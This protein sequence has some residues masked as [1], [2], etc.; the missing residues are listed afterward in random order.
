MNLKKTME[1][2]SVKAMNTDEL[3]RLSEE[4][5]E[6]LIDNVSQTGGHLASNLGAVE[7]TIALYKVFDF[8][9]DKLIFDVGH[10]S[11]V[12]KILSGRIDGFSRLRQYGGMSGFPKREESEFDV[13][14]SGHSSNSISVALGLKRAMDLK[15]EKGK[16]IAFIGDGALTGGMAYEALND[17]G[18]SNAGIIIILNDNEMSI[19]ENVG[20]IAKHLAKIR[21]SKKYYRIKS[22][23]T[24]V[25]EAVPIIGAPLKK[26]LSDVKKPIRDIAAKKHNNIFEQLGFYYAGPFDGHNIKEL[27]EAFSSVGTLN[28]PCVVHIV[29]KKGKGYEFAQNEPDLYHGVKKFDKNRKIER[30]KEENFSNV[31]GDCLCELA[32]EN[33]NIVAVT[34]AMPDGTGLNEFKNE[35]PERYYDV[36]IAEGHA[37]GLC[38]GLAIGNVVPV[39]AVYSAFL[40]RGYDQLLTDVC[41]MNLHCVFCVDRSGL[42]GEDGETHHG[43]FDIAYLMLIPNITVMSPSTYEEMKLMLKSAVYDYDSPVVIRYA[44]GKE[45]GVLK[46][47]ERPFEKGKA[48]VLKAGTDVSIICEG[49]MCGEALKTAELLEKDGINAEVVNLRYI[50]PLDEKTVISSLEKTKKGVILENGSKNG[51]IYSYISTLTDKKLV[52]INTGDKFVSQGSIKELRKELGMDFESIAY[53]IKKELF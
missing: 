47:Y 39:F 23:T 41:G 28:K 51:G 5:R 46:K 33:E 40:L 20:G 7:A 18:R 3:N 26:F 21:T 53:R 37:V 14:N 49:T 35:F 25:F 10:Q 22:R 24:R 34:A 8:P 19:S 43:V 12:H 42:V 2:K 50:K 27:T 48:V 17:A 6:F 52:G 9:K 38:S 29:T 13:L 32:K 30:R 11:Y 44:K 4:I 1:E 31:F 45:D 16:V 15:G 36:G